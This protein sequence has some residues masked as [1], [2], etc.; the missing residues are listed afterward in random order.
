MGEVNNK[1]TLGMWVQH[2][3]GISIGLIVSLFSV[4]LIVDT[5]FRMLY[6]FVPQI[7]EGLQVSITVFGWLLMIRSSSAIFSPMI[8]S[9]ADRY[10]RRKIMA[11][12]LLSQ[13]VGM[14][15]ISYATGWWTVLPLLF[16]GLTV[17][18]YL[19]AQQAYISDLV[20]F[21][22]RGRA[23]ASTDIAFAVSGMVMMPIV[24]RLIND[25]GWRTPFWGLSILSIIA[26]ILTWNYLPETKK[27]TLGKQASVNMWELLRR[28]N[29]QASM[30]VSM[31]FFVGVGIYMTF[32]S[33]WL[34]A[35][36]GFDALDLGLMAQQIGMAE[37]LGAILAGLVV[38]R[39]GKRRTSLIG[40]LASAIMFALIPLARENLLTIR[41]LLIITVFWVELGIVSLFPLY[42]EQAPNARATMFALI[43]LGNGIGLAVGPIITTSLWDWQGLAAITTVA[44]VSLALAAGLIALFLNDTVE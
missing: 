15:G 4:R 20:P 1:S 2:F 6:P 44:S 32:W 43:A 33:I 37:L 12:A 11:F 16:C 31:L 21:E 23:L 38:D 42:G 40:V 24:G 30:G 9:L 5:S 17:N 10:G 35:D 29:I 39:L 22:R 18:A 13:F 7:S 8:G 36:F 19:P 34:S 26:A 28:R 14:A 27:R 3:F 25:Y 41:I